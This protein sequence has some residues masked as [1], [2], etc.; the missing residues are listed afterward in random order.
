MSTEL[1][2]YARKAQSGWVEFQTRH[3][4]GDDGLPGLKTLAKVRDEDEPVGVVLRPVAF[5]LVQAW[6]TGQ[7]STALWSIV[8][9]GPRL[10]RHAVP[11]MLLKEAR[12][13]SRAGL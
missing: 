12:E 2:S 1:P 13:R 7:G 6:L 9:D 4:L 8:Q 10:I 5:G 11:R 3:G